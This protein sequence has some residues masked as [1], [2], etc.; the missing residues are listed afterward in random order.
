MPTST[1]LSPESFN[2]Y[3]EVPYNVSSV[4]TGRGDILRKLHDTCVPRQGQILDGVQNRYVIHGLG[5]SGKTQICLKFAHD[6]R[7]KYAHHYM[8]MI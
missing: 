6:C 2:Q 3:Y 4:F 5:G 1:D 8:T 7:E